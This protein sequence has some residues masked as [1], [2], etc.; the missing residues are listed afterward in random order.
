MLRADKLK[1]SS[2]ASNQ[3]RSIAEGWLHIFCEF[4]REEGDLRQPEDEP[5]PRWPRMC[6]CNGSYLIEV[7]PGDSTWHPCIL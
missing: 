3:Q 4:V 7:R 5:A 2:L 6:S 1:S